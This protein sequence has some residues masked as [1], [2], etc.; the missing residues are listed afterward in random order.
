MI[1]MVFGDVFTGGE[2]TGGRLATRAPLTEVMLRQAPKPSRRADVL[3]I[4]TEGRAM[5]AAPAAS[6]VYAAL[7]PLCET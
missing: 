5:P 3:V 7:S 4:T 1:M 2:A 6:A